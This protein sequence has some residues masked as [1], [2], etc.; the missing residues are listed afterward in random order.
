MFC[1][2][3]AGIGCVAEPARSPPPTVDGRQIS[4]GIADAAP[5]NSLR[6]PPW[7]GLRPSPGLLPVRKGSRGPQASAHLGRFFPGVDPVTIA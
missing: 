3:S 2:V 1:A 6:S 5:A 4:H 7:G